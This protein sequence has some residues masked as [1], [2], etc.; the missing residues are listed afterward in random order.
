MGDWEMEGGRRWFVKTAGTMAVAAVTA[1]MGADAAG[2]GD[3]VDAA[4]SCIKT[5]EAC[6]DHCFMAFGAGDTTLAR[7]AA[8][9][10]DMLAGCEAIVK[11]APQ[12]SSRLAAFVAACKD[13]CADCEAE[14]RKHAGTHEVCKQCADSCAR[15]VKAA[16]AKA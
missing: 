4:L 7:C 1:P 5:G 8:T 3:L 9:V 15:F 14:C 6:L 10:R 2:A 16:S 13:L 11:L 12:N